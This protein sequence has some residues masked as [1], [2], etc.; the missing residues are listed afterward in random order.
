MSNSKR[1][2]EIVGLVALVFAAACDTL[3]IDNPNDP[4][5]NR[6]LSDPNSI[7]GIG[8]GA[9][10]T[11]YLTTQG[12]F[13]EDQYPALTLSVMAR[14]HVAMWNNFNI[15]FYT[16]CT[17]DWPAGGYP[18]PLGTCGNLTEGPAYPRVEWQNNL[19]S[20]QRTQI[21]AMWYGYYASLSSANDVLTAIRTK[22]LAVPASHMVETMAVMTQGL[23]LSGIALNY[24]KGFVVDY[25]TD[26]TKLTFSTRAQIRDAALAKFD[27][28]ITM[29]ADTF[30]V[31][32]VPWFG[33]PSVSYNNVKIGKIANTMAARLLVY[34]PR[35]AAENKDVS[36]GGQ[37]DWA[38]VA[39]YASK[40]I[41]SGARF[42]LTFFQDA[43]TTWCDFLKVWSNDMT[44]MRV[45]TRVAHMMD[46]VSQPDPWDVNLNK[47]PTSP[48]KR[49]GDGTYRGP[50]AYAAAILRAY[51]DTTG[52]GGTDFVW[53]HTKEFGNKTRGAWHQSA[54]GQVRYDSLTTCGDNPQGE[55]TGTG[56]APMVLA[57]ENDLLWAEALIRRP[58]S[59]DLATA[60]TLI[61]NTR[62]TRGGLS[63]A[64]AS[65]PNLLQELQ[66][67]QDVELIGSNIAPLYNQRRTDNLEPLTPHEMP[68]P[69]QELGVLNLCTGACYTWGGASN[70]PNSSASAPGSSAAALMQSAPRIWA[71]YT[72]RGRNRMLANR[73]LSRL[74]H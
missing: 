64:N 28:A 49:L 37:V 26:I 68:V 19:A 27:T 22:K 4:D 11:W 31:P 74:V 34:F 59:P 29:A 57:A 54:V 6:V 36:A 62:V 43:C 32:S 25:N 40:G 10:Q 41:S 56:D 42:N 58:S 23:A 60:A 48:D 12:G 1:I 14:S 47:N 52:K 46:P 7:P 67:E 38:K 45:H 61:N 69:A 71:D 13:G 53:T 35:S 16:G 66:Y 21:E 50:A 18:A 24:D 9:F 44:T 33:G 17:Q 65:D 30:S 39:S 8:Q 70:P 3:S 5:R 15:R 20:A 2:R 73:V 51:P 55:V 72:Q 63:P